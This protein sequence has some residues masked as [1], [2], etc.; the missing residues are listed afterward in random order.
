M[1]PALHVRDPVPL[2]LRLELSAPTPRG[3]LPPLIGQ[4]L[5]RCSI[6]G[7]PARQCFENQH[8]SLMMRHRKTH[9]VARVIVQERRHIDA[10]MSSQQE[11]KEIRL[12]Q[13]VGLGPLEVLHHL[14]AAHALGRGLCLDAFGSQHP[15]HRRLGGAKPQE[16]PHHIADTPAARARRLLMRGEDRLR[17]RIGWL[18]R[19][20]TRSSSL[21]HLE[22]LFPALPVPLHPHHRRRVRHA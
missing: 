12:P 22:R 21:L 5:A 20:R 8:A 15:P 16:P 4:D 2:Q 13:L 6:V 1:R 11:G 3:V 10:F 14:L 18:L 19:G 17:A 7:D 9:E